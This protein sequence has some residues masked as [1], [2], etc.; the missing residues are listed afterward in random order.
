MIC[1]IQQQTMLLFI[2]VRIPE[3]STREKG[4]IG[5]H[6]VCTNRIDHTSALT[7]C[8]APS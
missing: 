8:P 1:V 3:T 5:T 2:T 4:D 7:E 6:R